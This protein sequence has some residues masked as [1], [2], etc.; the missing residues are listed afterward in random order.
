MDQE[1]EKNDCGNDFGPYLC[2]RLWLLIDV[3]KNSN[4]FI[5]IDRFFFW[6]RFKEDLSP[7]FEKLQES[8][9]F[10]DKVQF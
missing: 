10:V 7:R 3:G 9:N 5:L 4:D 8:S 6:R 1:L 2:E